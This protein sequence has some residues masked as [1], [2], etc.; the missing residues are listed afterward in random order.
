MSMAP[1]YARA[2]ALIAHISAGDH[3]GIRHVIAESKGREVHLIA[4]LIDAYTYLAGVY[5]DADTQTGLRML[6]AHH[7]DNG[8]PEYR[9]AA[10]A[11]FA[12][13]AVRHGGADPDVFVSVLVDADPPVD[14]CEVIAALAGMFGRAI[15][16]LRTPDGLARLREWCAGV[17]AADD[18]DGAEDFAP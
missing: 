18:D 4:A 9:T 8:P 11:V 14:G 5:L 15:P 13:A 10:R 3:A 7:V 1:D 6:L 2:V 17:L 12:F 16:Q